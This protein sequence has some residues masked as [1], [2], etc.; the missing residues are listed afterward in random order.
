MLRVGVVDPGVGSV[1][2]TRLAFERICGQLASPC[3]VRVVSTF[4]EARE[5]GS[6]VLGPRG[7]FAEVA[8]ALESS[9]LARAIR[10]HV[11]SGRPLLAI[12]LGL[13]VL[14]DHCQ[15]VSGLG[16]VPG[17][18][19]PIV[20]TIEVMSGQLSRVPHVGWNR[21]M[22]ESCPCPVVEAAGRPGTWVYFDHGMKVIPKDKAILS[23]TTEHGAESIVASICIGRLVGTQFRPERSQRAGIRMIVAFV[24][25]ATA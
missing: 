19:V 21:L 8:A 15:G 12:D 10:K 18:V 9:G 20:P 3:D 16:I 25:G 24:E 22:L 1:C 13:Q 6:L 14:F 4:D 5:C 11:D 17:E 2:S 7:T 23:S